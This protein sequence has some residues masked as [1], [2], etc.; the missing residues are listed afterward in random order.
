M[1]YSD[2]TLSNQERTEEQKSSFDRQTRTERSE[3]KTQYNV[4]KR[5]NR[6]RTGAGSMTDSN[7]FIDILIDS[8]KGQS[9]DSSTFSYIPIFDGLFN[10]AKEEHGYMFNLPLEIAEKT[11]KE[12]NQ[13]I[14][15]LVDMVLE[16]ID[17]IKI[18]LSKP[19]KER[20]FLH[21][22]LLELD[23][24]TVKEKD[25]PDRYT[26]L[27][28]D[29]TTQA[30]KILQRA[31]NNLKAEKQKERAEA[32]RKIQKE[33]QEQS[34]DRATN[35]IRYSSGDTLQTTGT[36]LANEFYSIT[37]PFVEL[38]GQLTLNTVYSNK[39]GSDIVV[40]S[41][42]HFNEGELN[43]YGIKRR[44]FKDSDY[45]VA[46]VCNNLF[47]EDNKQVSL[48]KIWHEMGNQNTPNPRQLQELRE[49]LVLGATT[50]LHISNKEVLDAWGANTDTYDD[51]VSPV[52]PAQIRT[53]YSRANGNI[54]NETI[55]INGISPFILVADPL[56]QISTWDK[57]ILKL[58]D[59]SRTNRYWSVLRYLM[60]EIAWMRNDTKRTNKITI[61]NL[62]AAVG[63]KT[64]ADKQRT[65]KMT[66]DLLEKVF[67]PLD[68]ICSYRTDPKDGGIILKYNKDRKPLLN[69]EN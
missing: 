11:T 9:S 69:S 58:Y 26:L 12:D 68:Y 23:Y 39:G 54:L 35:K 7:D 27:V 66:Y 25:K 45:F 32:A 22:V 16:A 64:R 65:L 15:S 21:E 62:C 24:K 56:N 48:T 55:Q 19:K 50:I 43:S 20:A 10:I 52:I 33:K 17:Y 38:E 34:K 57:R 53:V 3:R 30:G 41:W 29:P 36:K 31:L 67:K 18:E 42:F 5:T 28:K 47:L 2:Y 4:N 63:D 60:R 46:M 49:A 37:A 1:L 8:D 14:L 61:E 51:I 13:K 40:T 6:N 44:Q 59:G